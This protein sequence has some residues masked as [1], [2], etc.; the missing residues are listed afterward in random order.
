ME[1]LLGEVVF[2]RQFGYIICRLCSCITDH[3]T[4][5]EIVTCLTLSH[6]KH[7]SSCIVDQ[8]VTIICIMELT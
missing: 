5:S 6:Y 7:Q 3:N 2:A 8:E 1:Q 4:N